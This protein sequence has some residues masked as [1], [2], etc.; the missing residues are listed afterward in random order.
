M[1]ANQKN[2]ILNEK[3]TNYNTTD[4]TMDYVNAGD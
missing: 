1:N 3:C 2:G 4:P